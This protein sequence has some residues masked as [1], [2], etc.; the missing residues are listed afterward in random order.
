MDGWTGGRVADGERGEGPHGGPVAW[1]QDGG[2]RQCRGKTGADRS[3]EPRRRRKVVRRQGWGGRQYR[4]RREHD[5]GGEDVAAR[6]WRLGRGGSSDGE[7]G[8][9]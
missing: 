9:E 1:R 7:H 6:Q 2:R 3:V 5:T 8:R 4:S